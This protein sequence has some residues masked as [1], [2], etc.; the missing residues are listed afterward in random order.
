[1]TSKCEEVTNYDNKYI[2]YNISYNYNS[3]VK[4]VK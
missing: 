3:R 1:M 4:P 2:I